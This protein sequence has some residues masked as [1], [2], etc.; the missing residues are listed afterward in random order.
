MV[1][2]LQS[3]GVPSALTSLLLDFV[4]NRT[5]YVSTHTETSGVL[6]LNTGAPQ[7]CV[8]SPVLFVLY[9]ND[10][11][12]HSPTGSTTVMKYAD[13]TVIIGLVKDDD[14]SEYRNNIKSV[15]DWCTANHL[16]LNVSKTKE[17]VF[18]FRRN[19]SP[20]ST[21]RVDINGDQVE[22]TDTYKYLG[23]H[24]DAQL[25][26][27]Q[28]VQK[29]V[30]KANSRLHFLRVMAKLHV[31]TSIMSLFYQSSIC[32]ILLYSGSAF[33]HMLSNK[34][35]RDINKPRR[36]SSRIT[37]SSTTDLATLC[38]DRM[39]TVLQK[40]I[41][42][43]NHPLHSQL[44]FLPSGRLAMPNIRTTRFKKSFLCV[45][46]KKYNERHSR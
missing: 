12:A 13:D 1:D 20:E 38:K 25:S 41:Q 4:T 14:E 3:L 9:T 28:H 21:S 5:Q 39:Q 15:S 42:D 6:T 10:M 46:I 36:K 31:D 16:D 23:L 33:Y 22:V 17:I 35:E 29:Q 26:F 19:I 24:I 34:G 7:G 32:P 45:A 37:K 43:T 2:K 27:Q 11:R 18:D 8:L 40:I 44:R 30:A